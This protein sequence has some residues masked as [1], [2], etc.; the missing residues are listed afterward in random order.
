MSQG[1]FEKASQLWKME[2]YTVKRL[3]DVVNPDAFTQI[4]C[5][6]GE[7][8]RKGG[9]IL[10]TGKGASGIAARKLVYNLCSA[11]I[12]AIFLSLGEGKHATLGL[13][14][15]GDMLI[16]VS[17]GGCTS[18]L[19]QLIEP[20]REKNVTVLGVTQNPASMLG[21]KCDLLLRIMVVKD[22]E[23]KDP[24]GNAST[25][26]LIAILDAVCDGVINCLNSDL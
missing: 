11:D 14:K 12:P 9:R 18:D 5:K 13:L 22:V 8:I 26:A 6:M 19:V 24:L 7:V 21:M 16:L 15:S 4:V 17:K 23:T 3:A 1:I 2:T 10:V 25:I 20:A